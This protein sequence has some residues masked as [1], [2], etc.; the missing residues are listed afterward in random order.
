MKIELDEKQAEIFG[1]KVAELLGL[2]KQAQWFNTSIGTKT[3][4]GLG[5]TIARLLDEVRQTA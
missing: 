1:S 4:I 3:E 2:K 5:L